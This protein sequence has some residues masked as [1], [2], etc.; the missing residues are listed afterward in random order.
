MTHFN[1]SILS[2]ADYEYAHSILGSSR[3]RDPDLTIAPD[4][5]P[6]LYR[7]HVIPQNPLAN[8]YFHVQVASDPERPP[9]DHPWD[10][11]SAI[12]SGGYD[13]LID[14]MPWM[15]YPDPRGMVLNTR[16]LRAGDVVHRRATEAHRLL[17]PTKFKY[18]MTLFS[19]GPK[20]RQWGFWF[21]DGWRDADVVTKMLSDGRSITREEYRDE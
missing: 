9:H 8:C 4:G 13:E 1:P 3:L 15:H 5:A 10:N 11:T 12:I 14:F 18:T 2:A 7:W 20:V 17:L 16:Q 6:Y 21:D 19:T